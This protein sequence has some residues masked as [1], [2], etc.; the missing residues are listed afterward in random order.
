MIKL[1]EEDD[2]RQL[3]KEVRGI[4][5]YCIYIKECMSVEVKAN[6]KPWYHDIKAYIKNSEYP[7][8]ATDS[9]KKFIQHIAYEYF[10]SREVLYKRNP[11]FTLLQCMDTS[12]V[13]HLMEEMHE[14]LLGVHASGPLLACKIMRA[15]Y[16]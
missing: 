1:S 12:E 5:S 7:S 14:G 2:M 9:E 16:Y 6:G 3:H 4:P 10:L 13:N 8:G 11:D 15:S